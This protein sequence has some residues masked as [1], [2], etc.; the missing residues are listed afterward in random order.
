MNKYGKCLREVPC[1]C[2][3]KNHGIQREGL[4]FLHKLLSYSKTD[5]DMYEEILQFIFYAIEEFPKSK[6]IIKYS[7]LCF[8]ILCLKNV[9]LNY[10]S[11]HNIVNMLIC[12]FNS[13][14][15]IS[16]SSV[17]VGKCLAVVGSLTFVIFNRQFSV[18]KIHLAI[19]RQV[20]I[21]VLEKNCANQELV[22]CYL[23]CLHSLYLLQM[24]S[25]L[26]EISEKV[27]LDI[28]SW[29]PDSKEIRE[30]AIVVVNWATH[31]HKQSRAFDGLSGNYE[32]KEGMFNFACEMLDSR[33]A[34]SQ[35]SAVC[36]LIE[37]N[38]RFNKS[39]NRNLSI[40][41]IKVMSD[42]AINNDLTI[43]WQTLYNSQVYPDLCPDSELNIGFAIFVVLHVLKLD[44]K[45]N[46][47]LPL[48]HYVS[49]WGE[50][51]TLALLFKRLR[52][53]E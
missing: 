20:E 5:I 13:I 32:I 44:V 19:N 36:I 43:M 22:Y 26:K 34:L 28:I 53:K 18:K 30:E 42:C 6:T 10:L 51:E 25:M 52:K 48:I 9:S 24:G 4:A 40:K 7:I 37:M 21:Y 2:L 35:A 15:T 31:M 38:R 50:I 33:C 8:E 46:G 29:F 1:T 3:W 39:I 12:C 23:K 11:P 16:I 47:L 27:L 17:P 49:S 41:I 45:P 14:D